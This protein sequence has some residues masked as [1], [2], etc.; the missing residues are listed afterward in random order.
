MYKTK[1]GVVIYQTMMQQQHVQKLQP[2]QCLSSTCSLN[3]SP[4][5]LHI[6]H[7]YCRQS[8][9]LETKRNVKIV[10]VLGGVVKF[11]SF[12]TRDLDSPNNAWPWMFLLCEPINSCSSP[13][14]LSAVLSNFSWLY[15][16]LSPLSP[17][18]VLWLHW[19]SLHGGAT[20]LGGTEFHKGTESAPGE[21]TSGSK[22]KVLS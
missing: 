12:L 5:P 1:T 14:T 18:V 15:S 22:L 20:R 17:V 9:I 4:V 6:W 21:Q 7:L 8:T 11:S 2:M 19:R 3:H 10:F 16:P 13:L